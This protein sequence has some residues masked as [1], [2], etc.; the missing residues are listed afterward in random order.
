MTTSCTSTTIG[1]NCIRF[2]GSEIG[3]NG[4]KSI[5]LNGNTIQVTLNNWVLHQNNTFKCFAYSV[6]GN[7][8]IA[9]SNV[10]TTNG[11]ESL[12]G[13]VGTY[14]A[15]ITVT[16]TGNR[17]RTTQHTVNSVTF[18]F[19]ACPA[20]SG[21]LQASATEV[22]SENTAVNYSTQFF[23]GQFY[24]WYLDNQ[25]I[26]G[27]PLNQVTYTTPNN[28]SVGQHVVKLIISNNCRFEEFVSN[29]LVKQSPTAT[30]NDNLNI[31]SGAVP[32]GSQLSLT[33]SVANAPSAT[34]EHFT[35]NVL[36]ASQTNVTSGSYA[37]SLVDGSHKVVV[38]ATNP[39]GCVTV[40]EIAFNVFDPLAVPVIT[41]NFS[42][43]LIDGDKMI[44]NANYILNWSATNVSTNDVLVVQYAFAPDAILQ[45]GQPSP[46][47]IGFG[48]YVFHFTITNQFGITGSKTLTL[49]GI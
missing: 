23:P 1:S 46:F 24:E 7:A 13:T 27:L 21:T 19:T 10:N 35:N 33:W 49:T 40:K 42:P 37:V 6:S 45:P 9:C 48:V 14:C 30:I 36:V 44:A 12:N 8:A 20:I 16:G 43:E 18:C 28:L 29:L 25:F 4:T 32:S 22:C 5:V 34:F 41:L 26:F 31:Q 2:Q 38:S 11:N 47:G 3:V 15:P 17:R 39:N